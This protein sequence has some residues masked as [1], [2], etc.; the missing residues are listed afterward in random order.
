MTMTREQ[1]RRLANKLAQAQV[2]EA[3]L[4]A[5]IADWQSELESTDPAYESMKRELLKRQLEDLK[6]QLKEAQAKTDALRTR[7][8]E[9]DVPQPEPMHPG[10]GVA[11]MLE[12]DKR[13]VKWDTGGTIDSRDAEWASPEVPGSNRSRR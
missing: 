2:T 6:A 9:L 12:K 10:G 4:R 5:A 11:A 3:D 1:R 13:P 7:C 8:R